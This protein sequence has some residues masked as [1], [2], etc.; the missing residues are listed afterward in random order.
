MVVPYAAGGSVDTIARVIAAKLT[1]NMG[2][3]V[4]VENRT[5]AG[6]N[7]GADVVAKS[8]PDGYTMLLAAGGLAISGGLYKNLPF[9]PVKDFTPVT[10]VIE[11]AFILLE[12]P[13]VPATNSPRVDRARQGQARHHELRIERRRQCA[14][15]RN[16]GLQ[17]LRR[18]RAWCISRIAATRRS[19][20]R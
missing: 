6:G 7:T 4:I 12:S 8:P 16:R 17:K 20:L 2:Q 1:E 5:G 3:P 14:A 18:H 11:T 15:S 13:K 19:T 9:D 10:Q